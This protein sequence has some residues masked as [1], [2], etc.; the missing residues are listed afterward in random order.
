MR[1]DALLLVI[2]P[3]RDFC[4][5]GGLAVPDGDAV[6]PLINR[7]AGGFRHVVVTQDWHP[8]GHSS[9]AS[10]H[11]G[12][13][14]YESIQM[15]YGQQTLWPDHCVQGT[16][17][18]EFHPMLSLPHAELILRK[19]FQPRIDSYSA[20]LENDRTTPTGL[21][22]YLSERGFRR[23]IVVGLALDFCVRF[24]ATD[25]LRAGFEMVV[26]PEACRAVGLPGSVESTWREFAALGVGTLTVEELLETA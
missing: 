23:I 12:K 26:L 13:Q 14:P 1:D 15:P 11:L 21:F 22:G 3:Q 9:F 6:I 24:S 25:G 5:G 2:D 8:P 10:S 18:A 7:L 19:G 17:G 16:L 20:F 4:L